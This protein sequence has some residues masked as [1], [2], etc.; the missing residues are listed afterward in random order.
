[1]G[2]LLRPIQTLDYFLGECTAQWLTRQISVDVKSQIGI[3]GSWVKLG[4]P[5]VTWDCDEHTRNWLGV[6]HHY[7][8]NN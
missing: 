6:E 8:L 1:M 3:L 4:V 5:S 7:Q 2:S